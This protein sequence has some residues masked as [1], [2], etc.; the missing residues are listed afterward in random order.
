MGSLFRKISC[1]RPLR[2]APHCINRG[3]F[4]LRSQPRHLRRKERREREREIEITLWHWEQGCGRRQES[5]RDQGES[6]LG[7]RVVVV[8]P[9]E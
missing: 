9:S 5:L 1:N 2:P 3:D 4:P 7:I 6:L 8:L